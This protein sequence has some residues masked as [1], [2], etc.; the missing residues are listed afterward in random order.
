MIPAADEIVADI[1]FRISD[2]NRYTVRGGEGS[3][4]CIIGVVCSKSRHGGI[5]DQF[6]KGVPLCLNKEV[7]IGHFLRHQ[8]VPE[9]DVLKQEHI[10]AVHFGDAQGFPAGVPVPFREKEGQM[11]FSPFSAGKVIVFWTK[12]E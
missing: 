2:G 10:F 1:K 11:F 5:F 3:G 12:G 8:I 4:S 9:S 7:G 6:F